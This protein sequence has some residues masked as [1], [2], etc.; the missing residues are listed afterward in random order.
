[1][2]FNRKVRKSEGLDLS[3]HFSAQFWEVSARD[4]RNVEAALAQLAQTLRDTED[5]DL[6]G[7]AVALR[8][9]GGFSSNFYD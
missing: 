4:G 3:S 8:S 7:A 5:R 6:L 2:Y 1:M 9:A